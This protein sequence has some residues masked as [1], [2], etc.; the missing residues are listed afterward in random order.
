VR[1]ARVGTVCR[2]RPRVRQTTRFILLAGLLADAVDDAVFAAL[3]EADDADEGS[4]SPRACPIVDRRLPN[5]LCCVPAGTA[6]AG[7]A[8][9][10]VDE[11][12]ESAAFT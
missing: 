2:P 1:I 8:E 9:V 7:S 3:D 11:S 4:C 12:V 5:K 10:S 6:P